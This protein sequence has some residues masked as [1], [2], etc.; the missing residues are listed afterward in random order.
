MP[1]HPFEYQRPTLEMVEQITL[2][3]E[4]CKALHDILLSLPPCR[5]RSLAITK[6]E[7]CSMWMNKGIVFQED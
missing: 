4:G 3:R 7:E 1:K 6:L 2:V 5:E